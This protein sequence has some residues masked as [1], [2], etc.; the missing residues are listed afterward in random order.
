MD[1]QRGGI[2]G[3]KLVSD[4][5]FFFLLLKQRENIEEVRPCGGGDRGA[6]VLP[7]LGLEPASVLHP[8]FQ[9]DALPTEVLLLH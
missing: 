9:S 4:S 7:R 5:S 8:A 1:W 2:S 3:V 6:G